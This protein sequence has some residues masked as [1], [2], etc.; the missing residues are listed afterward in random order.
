MT[1]DVVI[2]EQRIS[3]AEDGIRVILPVLQR[4]H[5]AVIVHQSI[6]ASQQAHVLRPIFVVSY[7]DRKQLAAVKE[8]GSDFIVLG[9]GRRSGDYARKINTAAA[10]TEEPWLFTAADDLFFH[11]GWAEAAMTCARRKRVQVVGTNDM[12]RWSNRHRTPPSTHFLVARSYFELGGSVGETEMI[13]HTGYDHNYVDTEFL[14]TATARKQYEYCREAQVEHLHPVWRKGRRD[15]VYQLG[16]RQN[17][18]DL[19]LY[20]QRERLWKTSRS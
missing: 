9:E 20:R 12:G 4:P 11:P 5:R 6:V 16:Q 19:N 13:F 1:L 2:A 8:T 3:T 18:T 14:W 15:E 7:G 17:R 10:L